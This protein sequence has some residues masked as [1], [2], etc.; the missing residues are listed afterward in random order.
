MLYQS[1]TVQNNGDNEMDILDW[2]IDVSE[3]A[4]ACFML[5]FCGSL[6]VVT[7]FVV[8]TKFFRDWEDREDREDRNDGH[9]V[10]GH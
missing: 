2:I 5:G 10:I 6:G 1:L 7:A 3:I 8:G 4:I 9:G